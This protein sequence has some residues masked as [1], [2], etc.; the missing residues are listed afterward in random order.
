MNDEAWVP[1]ESPTRRDATEFDKPFTRKRVGIA[2]LVSIIVIA[3]THYITHR[4]PEPG[5]IE[6]PSFNYE[7]QLS[8][9][10]A[11]NL[12]AHYGLDEDV[13]QYLD[14]LIQGNANSLRFGGKGDDQYAI[15]EMPLRTEGEDLTWFVYKIYDTDLMDARLHVYSK[16]QQTIK[17]KLRDYNWN[18]T[19][20]SVFED[21]SLDLLLVPGD[22]EDFNPKKLFKDRKKAIEHGTY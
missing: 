7:L 17:A 11:R 8:Y 2:A 19:S 9:D 5:R 12:F 15:L 20:D 4:K 14:E 13:S 21:A 10:E 18:V 3:G 16:I 1:E 22:L 6:R